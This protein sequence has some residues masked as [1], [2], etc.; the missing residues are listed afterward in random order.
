MTISKKL[1]EDDRIEDEYDITVASEAYQD[2][3]DSGKRSTPVAD[4]WRE[5]DETQ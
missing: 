4:F 1:T 5:L 3:L 2:Y